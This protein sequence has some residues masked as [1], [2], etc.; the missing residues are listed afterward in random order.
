MLFLKQCGS[1]LYIM[2]ILEKLLGL[3]NVIQ[4]IDDLQFINVDFEMD[5]KKVVEY[6]NK[7]RKDIIEFGFIMDNS[8]QSYSFHLTNS[9]V[10]FIRR[11]TN[12][13][14]H[15]FPATSLPSLCIFNKSPTCITDL[16]NNEMI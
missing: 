13:V 8:I 1:L 7:G 5:S 6:F 12:E 9:C 10:E 11:Q 14:V 16:I 2:W 3:Y 4:C 15:E